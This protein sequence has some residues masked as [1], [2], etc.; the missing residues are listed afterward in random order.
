[1][2]I[3]SI[4]I[5]DYSECAEGMPHD[6]ERLFFRMLLKMLSRENGLPDDDA[7]NARIF[8][9]KD[10]RTYRAL[11]AKLLA[12][13]N[14]IAIRDGL[15]TNERVEDDLEIYRARKAS[16]AEHGRIGGRSTRDRKTIDARSSPEVQPI[17]HATTPQNNN[18]VQP[19][20]SPSPSPTPKDK[21]L[22]PIADTGSSPAGG[23]EEIS[24]LNG[25]TKMIVEQFANWLNPW[26]P[27]LKLAHKSIADAVQLYGPNAV[28]DGFAELTAK[29]RDGEVRALTTT[30]F[31]GFVKRAK[32]RDRS[33]NNPPPKMSVREVL[34]ARKAAQEAL[35]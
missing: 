33:K 10:I 6:V 35:Q 32:E 4:S 28:R 19:S 18:L 30:A 14:A 29:Q 9:Y 26:A 5:A 1:M 21:N 12:W 16:A 23:R 8:G 15:I 17:P 22:S 13:P 7:E 34:A 2:K 25:S 24:G 3:A 27:D 20:P 11:K 31:Y